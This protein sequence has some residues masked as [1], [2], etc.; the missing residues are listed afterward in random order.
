MLEGFEQATH[1]RFVIFRR[2][3]TQSAF[4]SINYSRQSVLAQSES[5][6]FKRTFRDKREK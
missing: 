6:K 2:Y 4:A 5:I 1:S 3:A